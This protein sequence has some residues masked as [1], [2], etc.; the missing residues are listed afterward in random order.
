MD[1]TA[2]TKQATR[3]RGLYHQL[4]VRQ[5]GS[6]WDNLPDRSAVGCWEGW[7]IACRCLTTN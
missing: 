5:E 4:E 3:I 6:R 2:A 1:L 7:A